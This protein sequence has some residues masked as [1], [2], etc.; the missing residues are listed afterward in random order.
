MLCGAA[1][2]AIL[3]IG[4]DVDANGAKLLEVRGCE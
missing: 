4:E 1:V 3:G 2:L